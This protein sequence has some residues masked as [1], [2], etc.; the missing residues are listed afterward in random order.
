MPDRL[1]ITKNKNIFFQFLGW[2][3]RSLYAYAQMLEITTTSGSKISLSDS[4]ILLTPSSPQYAG[5]LV[6]EDKLIHC[7]NNSTCQEEEIVTILPTTSSGFWA[8]L[9]ATGTIIVDGFLASCYASFPH[10][11]KIL[12]AGAFSFFHIYFS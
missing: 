10:Q 2:L 1:K 11:V 6:P 8:P 7:F 3:D 9:T 5:D 4:H 12:N